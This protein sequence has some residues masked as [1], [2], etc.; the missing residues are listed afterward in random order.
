MTA[1]GI[2][3]EGTCGLLYNY[4]YHIWDYRGL[5]GTFFWNQCNAIFAIAWFI[6]FAIVIPLIDYIDW[7]VFHYKEDTPPYYKIFGKV[8]FQFKK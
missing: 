4:D 3:A 2:L 5:P 6:L 1:I 7:R 8:I